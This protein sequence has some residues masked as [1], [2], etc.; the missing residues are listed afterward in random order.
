M[1]E[2][3]SWLMKFVALSCKVV[4]VVGWLGCSFMTQTAHA[5]LVAAVLPSS[6]SVQVGGSPATAFAT[7]INTAQTPATSCSIA[8]QTSVAAAFLY[9]TTDPAT[10]AITGTANTP[11]DIPAGQAQTFV[12]VLTPTVAFDPI[13]VQLI[14]DCTNTDPAPITPGLNTLLLSAADSAI[15]DIVAL[16]ATLQSDGIVNLSNTGVFSVATVNVGA[17]GMMTAI[18]EPSPVGLP[19][20]VRI[21]ETNST[22]GACASPPTSSVMIPIN[23]GATPTFGVFVDGTGD[24][25][26]DPAVN[27]V[28]VRF[29]D[30]D[31][32]IR[33][34]TSIAVR[35]LPNVLGTYTGTG[36]VTLSD[37]QDANDNRT[38]D[39][40][41]TTIIVSSQTGTMIGG[42]AELSTTFNGISVREVA[43][44]S[45]ILTSEGQVS[46]T[47]DFDFF[48][49]GMLNSQGSGTF[50]GSVSDNTLVF[51]STGL[52]MGDTCTFTGITTVTR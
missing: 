14:F 8:P 51:Q 50:T 19:T 16:A 32:V 28:F 31:Q 27:R 13:D 3:G 29:L 11:V 48:V 20:T 9:Q 37:C 12:L 49:G 26:F 40:V 17:S 22:T 52:T 21:C 39:N 4:V 7:L 24:I 42:T 36:S 10:N 15:P 47:F 46:G 45:G 33:G 41:A 43:D 44:F 1:Q 34:A 6:R 25:P 30:A 5:Q 23:A 35:T 18:A 2:K 38:F